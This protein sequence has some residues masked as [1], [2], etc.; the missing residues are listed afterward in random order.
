MTL[1]C[2]H[3]RGQLGAGVQRYWHMRFCSA[4]CMQAYQRRLKESTRRKIRRLDWPAQLSRE[5]ACPG[6]SGVVTGIVRPWPD[7]SAA[8][9]A[10]G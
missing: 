10:L 7:R 9:R 3:C 4:V 2:D 8:K 1:R 6:G 5:I